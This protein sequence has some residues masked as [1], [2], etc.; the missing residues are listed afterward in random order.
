M[1][2]GTVRCGLCCSDRSHHVFV[3]IR[4]A[5]TED[6]VAALSRDLNL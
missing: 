5:G 2:D 3:A 1:Y 6:K 4:S